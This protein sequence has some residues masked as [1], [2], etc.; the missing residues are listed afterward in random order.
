MM[1]KYY[2]EIFSGSAKYSAGVLVALDILTPI[3]QI[4][5]ACNDNFSKITW[6]LY[7]AFIVHAMLCSVLT[8][9]FSFIGPL[10]CRKK[11]MESFAQ[12]YN[13]ANGNPTCFFMNCVIPA[14]RKELL[15][16]PV[17]IVLATS[18]VHCVSLLVLSLTGGE[19]MAAANT[20]AVVID[21]IAVIFAPLCNISA[22]KEHSVIGAVMLIIGFLLI[23]AALFAKLIDNEAALPILP[24]PIRIA[25]II[26]AFLS[27]ILFFRSTVYNGEFA[28]NGEK[29]K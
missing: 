13:S 29:I 2:S 24:L 4:I 7:A 16:L 19:E 20:A 10:P 3:L 9:T 21:S 28:R 12:M 27:N 11:S 8:M 5:P 14:K 18:A 23:F 22:K 25:I 17:K 6:W 26:I 15:D 1:K